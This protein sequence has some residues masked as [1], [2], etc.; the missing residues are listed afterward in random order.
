MVETVPE[1][2][3]ERIE[4]TL[5]ELR[6]AIEAGGD[7][8]LVERA[9]TLE[10]LTGQLAS[11]TQALGEVPAPLRA[12]YQ[13]CATQANVLVVSCF[14]RVTVV[15]NLLRDLGLDSGLYRPVGGVALVSTESVSTLA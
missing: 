5:G 13:A 12:R 14:W 4:A 15:A 10:A 11:V 6:G 2:L 3:I 7:P 1:A 9:H 8:S